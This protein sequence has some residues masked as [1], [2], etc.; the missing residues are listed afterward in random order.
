V[1]VV[2]VEA[3]LD[4]HGNLRGEKKCYSHM[5]NY[6]K[7]KTPLV[8]GKMPS[9]FTRISVNTRSSNVAYYVDTDN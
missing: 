9:W 8:K 5:V 3:E 2:V 1:V 4:D 7:D 6:L